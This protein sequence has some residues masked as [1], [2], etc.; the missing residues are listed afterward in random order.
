MKMQDLTDTARLLIASDKG[1]RQW[2]IREQMQRV[3]EL[4]ERLLNPPMTERHSL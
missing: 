1:C 3:A 2:T 4:V